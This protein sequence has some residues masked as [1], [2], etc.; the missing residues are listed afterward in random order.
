MGFHG[1]FGFLGLNPPN[2]T[3]ESPFLGFKI[4]NLFDLIFDADNLAVFKYLTI[5]LLQMGN[6][7]LS[8]LC[9]LYSGL[10]W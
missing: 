8:S 3:M 6:W 10:K 7:M 2:I 5:Y 4:H 1:S 9:G